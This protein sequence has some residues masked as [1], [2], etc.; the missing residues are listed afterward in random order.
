[1]LGGRGGGIMVVGVGTAR[2]QAIDLTYC[3]TYIYSPKGVLVF[4]YGLKLMGWEGN[5]TYIEVIH[6]GK[7]GGGQDL[8]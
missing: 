4:E 6:E 1:M 8:E 7:M 5:K 2:Y 3:K